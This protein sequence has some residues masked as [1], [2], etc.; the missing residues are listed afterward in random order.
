MIVKNNSDIQIETPEGWL[1]SVKFTPWSDVVEVWIAN[2]RREVG[3]IDIYHFDDKGQMIASDFKEGASGPAPTMIIN[4]RIWEGIQRAFQG[5]KETPEKQSVDAE[6][7]A[8]KNHLEDM[9]KIVF[10]KD[11]DE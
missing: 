2:K 3:K 11:S 7:K 10:R 5:I 8:T 1:I 9:R 4:R 6:L